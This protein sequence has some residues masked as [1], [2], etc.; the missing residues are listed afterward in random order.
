MR[1]I[2]FR[3][4]D[5][6][7]YKIVYQ[8]DKSLGHF[9][10]MDENESNLMQFTGLCDSKG[11]EIYE[12]DIF[13]NIDT[14]DGFRVGEYKHLVKWDDF[15]NGWNFKSDFLSLAGVMVAGN[16]CENEDLLYE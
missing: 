15:N 13:T 5:E 6:T 2:R 10:L 4:W 9:I 1:D 11:V 3:A 16:I 14:L 7:T 12:N 8:E